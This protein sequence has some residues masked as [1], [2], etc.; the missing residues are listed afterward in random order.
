MSVKCS[1]LLVAAGRLFGSYLVTCSHVACGVVI[2][3]D[4]LVLYCFASDFFNCLWSSVCL[5][6]LL[7]LRVELLLF[8]LVCTYVFSIVE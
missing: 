5:Y 7:A 1:F 4:S 8:V 2:F 3:G 6:L